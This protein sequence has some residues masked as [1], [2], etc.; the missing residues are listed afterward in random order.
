LSLV[1][2]NG[3]D[4]ILQ[5]DDLF[6]IEVNPRSQGTI[7]CAEASLGINMVEAHLQP[8]RGT[9]I[10]LPLPNRFAVKMIV[11]ARKRSQVGRMNFKG[12]NDIPAEDVIIEEG[13]PVATVVSSNEVLEDA[14][15]SAQQMVSKVYSLLK[16]HP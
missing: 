14:I 12:V 11:H 4:F 10:D 1:G 8:T 5:D 3:V 16:V 7:E 6:F 15:Y 2:S 9:L 13:E